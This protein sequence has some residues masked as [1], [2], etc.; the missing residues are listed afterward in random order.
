MTGILP[1]HTVSSFGHGSNVL[2]LKICNR[3]GTSSTSSNSRSDPEV[4]LSCRV[5]SQTAVRRICSV[6]RTG[7]TTS[8]TNTIGIIGCCCHCTVC[9]AGRRCR[10]LPLNTQVLRITHLKET[11]YEQIGRAHV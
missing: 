11:F 5:L 7:A 4:Q 10:V 2:I 8:A 1:P 6:P 9:C 3:S